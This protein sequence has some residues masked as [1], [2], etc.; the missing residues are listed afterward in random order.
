MKLKELLQ[1]LETTFIKGPVDLEIK[2]IHYDS[3]KIA[4]HGLFVATTGLTFDGHDFIDAAK[5]Q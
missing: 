4:Q 5:S 2:N 3:R 1:G